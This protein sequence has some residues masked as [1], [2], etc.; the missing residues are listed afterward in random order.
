MKIIHPGNK[1]TILSSRCSL[2]ALKYS[3]NDLD[4]RPLNVAFEQSPVSRA[5]V[6]QLAKL[7]PHK[8]ISL[9]DNNLLY[10]FK[11]PHSWF[12]TNPS[13]EIELESLSRGRVLQSQDDFDSLNLLCAKG[14][15]A[16]E[17][18]YH[19]AEELAGR[20]IVRSDNLALISVTD[21]CN[22]TCNH[23]VADANCNNLKDELTRYEL[24]QVFSQ[25]GRMPNPLGLNVEKKVF[26]S[27]GEPSM[28][29]DLEEIIKDACR[30][31]LSVNVCT[32]GLRIRDSMLANLRGLPVAFSVS[33]DGNL[34]QHEEIRGAGTYGRTIQTIKDIKKNGYG[35][36]INTFLHQGNFDSIPML[37]EQAADLGASGIN[38]IRAIPR[39]R[40]KRTVYKRVPDAKLFETL[41]VLMKEERAFYNLLKN[42]N[43]FPILVSSI[44]AGVKSLNCGLSRDNYLFLDCEGNIYPCPGTRYPE[45]KLGNIRTNGINPILESRKT[46]WLNLLDAGAFPVCSKCSFTYYCGGDCR[47][48]AYGNSEPK[49]IKM[50]VPYCSERKESLIKIFEILSKD[51]EFMAKRAKIFIQNAR[52]EEGRANAN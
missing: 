1:L 46:H 24:N 23:C 34:E 38:F 51:P 20:Y 11:N 22:L 17:G 44:A 40:G 30:E 5:Q 52:E 36:F 39:G 49:D 13:S 7:A 2:D 45:F 25:I 21:R 37:V 14:I 18:R 42:E 16:L 50:P 10:L 43:T 32:N 9:S 48:S 6:G 27:G 3:R 8:K 33:L 4:S 29:I 19:P 47:G 35:L 31:G 15:I 26:I 41:Y 28:R 12:I